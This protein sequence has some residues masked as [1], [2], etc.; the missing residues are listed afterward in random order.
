MAWGDVVRDDGDQ[1]WQTEFRVLGD[2]VLADGTVRGASGSAAAARLDGD[3][4]WALDV[5]CAH[6]LGE[7]A[8]GRAGLR[9]GGPTT[10]SEGRDR[11]Y[12][13]VEVWDAGGAGGHGATMSTGVFDQDAGLCSKATTSSTYD[14]VEGQLIVTR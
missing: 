14:V 4:A 7:D 6:S 2:S 12:I 9:F 10:L 11:P 13:L 3:G 8:D 1:T 5:V